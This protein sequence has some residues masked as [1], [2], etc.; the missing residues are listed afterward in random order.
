MHRVPSALIMLA[1][2]V[3]LGV[4]VVAG[5]DTVACSGF[6][7]LFGLE[8]PIVPSGFRIAGLEEPAPPAAA[9]IV[10]SVGGHVD[11]VFFADNGF[12]DETKV[13]GNRIAKR[14]ADELA[15]I[16]NRELDLEVFVPIGVDLEF[17]LPDPLGV[18][19]DN[20]AD[21]EVVG[22]LEFFQSGPDC[23]E[24]VPSLRIEPDLAAKILHGLHFGSDDVL[25]GIVVGQEHAIIF[26]S[27]SLGAVRPVGAHL[28]QNL[29]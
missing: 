21:F 13:F 22:N 16:L 10:R 27:P 19:L 3:N 7:D 5:G 4:A 17:T 2:V 15:G 18:I 26:G 1:Q 8:A 28:V 6:L 11:E 20:A 24:F 29:P 9:V 12:H 14:L 23:K 25:P